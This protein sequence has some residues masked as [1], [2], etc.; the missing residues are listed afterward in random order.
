MKSR[1]FQM[2]ENTDVELGGLFQNR[3]FKGTNFNTPDAAA[4]DGRV[5]G[6]GGETGLH[7]LADS[8][9]HVEVGL[10]AL[11]DCG[12]APGAP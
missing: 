2:N 11:L 7:G 10:R 3:S 9:A 5:P 6:K 12:S 8:G 4:D 1:Q